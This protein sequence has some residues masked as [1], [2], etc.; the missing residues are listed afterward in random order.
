MR[1]ELHDGLRG[2][3]SV[4]ATRVVVYDDFDNPIS[5]VV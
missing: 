4:R 3:V 5:V 2:A 1:V